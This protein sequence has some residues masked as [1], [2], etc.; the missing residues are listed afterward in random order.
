MK[1]AEIKVETFGGSPLALHNMPCACCHTNYAV[2]DL[3]TGIFQPCWG[4]R[5]RGWHV[6]KKSGYLDSLWQSITRRR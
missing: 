6:A 4:C 1:L 2:L 3:S 5:G